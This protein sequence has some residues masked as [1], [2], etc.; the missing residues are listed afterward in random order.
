M[1]RQLFGSYSDR[2]EHTGSGKHGSNKGMMLLSSVL[3]ALVWV[4]SYHYKYNIGLFNTPVINIWAFTLW[5]LTGYIALQIIFYFRARVG[6]AVLI[7]PLSWIIY[8]AGL[9]LFEYIGYYVLNIRERSAQPADALVFGV[10]HGPFSLHA[11]YVSF[12]IL[13]SGVYNVVLSF[14]AYIELQVAGVKNILFKDK[15]KTW[16]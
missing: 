6:H 8:F 1:Y 10:I 15:F 14:A 4:G 7:L 12:P 13:I 5:V 2:Q 11:Y 9:L 16:P 3:M